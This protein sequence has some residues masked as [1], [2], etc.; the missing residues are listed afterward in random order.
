MEQSTVNVES[1]EIR[2][3]TKI[4]DSNPKKE[5]ENNNKKRSITR[6]EISRHN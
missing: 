1:K 4:I 6:R 3:I 5:G 2:E